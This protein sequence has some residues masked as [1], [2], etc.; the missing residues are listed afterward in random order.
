M[1]IKY[2]KKMYIDLTKV[3]K[4]KNDQ[5]WV[6]YRVLKLFSFLDVFIK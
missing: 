1:F 4:K 3:S 5:I 6:K 2:L